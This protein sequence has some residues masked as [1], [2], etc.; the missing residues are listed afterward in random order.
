[1]IKRNLF[2]DLK[3]HCAQKEISLL[4]GPRQAGK[5][6]L[7]LMLRDYL[8]AQGSNTLFLSLDFNSDLPFFTSQRHLVNKIELEIGKNKGY[9]F[10]DE[11]QR[12]DDAGLFLKGLYDLNLP[13]KLIVSGSG[14]IEL[15]EK[16]H[17]SLVG[18]K[19]IF[20]LNTVS[21]KEFVNYKTGYRYEDSL[22]LFFELEKESTRQFLIEYLNF[23]GYPR[24]LL[25]EEQK[26]KIRIIDEIYRSYLER[27]ISYLLRVEKTEAFSNLIKVLAAQIGRLVNYSELSSTLGIALQTIKKYLWYAEKTFIM[28]RITPFFRNTRKEITKSPVAYFYDVGLRNYALG[29]YGNLIT[30]SETGFVFQNFIFNLMKEKVLFSPAEIHFW[31]TKDKAEVDFVITLGQRMLP[32]EVKFKKLKKP[33]IGRSLRSFISR[34]QPEMAWVINT[35]LKKKIKLEKTEISFLPFWDI[36]DTKMGKQDEI[37]WR[38]GP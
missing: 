21:F 28:Q 34:Y 2:E 24:L 22:G 25:A 26:E 20:E 3:N 6:T 14:S 18:R 7:M 38:F 5:T 33:E 19:R 10:I 13:Y 11:I 31:R 32:V 1:M 30:P 35:E 12:R 4:V 17:E 23:G 8:V 9:V 15:K 36:I 37:K 16:I 29:L 27:D